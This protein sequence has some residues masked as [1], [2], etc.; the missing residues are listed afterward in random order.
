MT[1]LQSL[2][3]LAVVGVILY[4]FL[5][6]IMKKQ[7]T[8][9][10]NR[11]LIRVVSQNNLAI[12]KYITIARIMSHYYVL[13]IAE[14]HIGMIS[15]ITEK[16][17]IDRLKVLESEMPVSQEITFSDYLKDITKP[18]LGKKDPVTGESTDGVLNF[19]KKQKDRLNKLN[20]DKK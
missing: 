15:Q 8:G 16:D 14:N 18:I 12:G 5:K 2:L 13:S 17:E 6:F 20:G 3:L 4:Y 10:I 7:N 19:L 11:D 9:N 1:L